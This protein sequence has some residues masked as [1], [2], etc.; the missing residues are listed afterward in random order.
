MNQSNEPERPLW[1]HC[2]WTTLRLALVAIALYLAVAYLVMPLAWKGYERRHPSLEDIPGITYTGGGIPGDPLNVALIGTRSEIEAIMA[3]AAWR[4]A[5]PLSLRSDLQIAEATIA[6][7]SYDT[8]PVS[9]LFL[10]GRKEDL[11]FEKPSGDN[12]RQRN[13][14]RFWKTEKQDADGRPIWMGAAT[15]DSRVGLSHTTAQI[16]HHIDADI[17]AE[18]DRLFADLTATGMLA[19]TYA[20]ADFHTTREGRNGGGD[21]WRTDGAL[22]VGV[23]RPK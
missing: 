7:R 18:R 17:D 6:K 11:A 2:A 23:I 9:N 12:P 14:V 15:Y 3:A 21:P 8:A 20:I 1:R 10:F 19:E 16:T 13:H 22:R 4:P 5:D